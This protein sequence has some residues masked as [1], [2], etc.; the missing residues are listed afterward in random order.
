VPQGILCAC[1]FGNEAV[2]IWTW[3]NWLKMGLPGGLL[4]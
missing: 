3:S 4:W 2:R 1:V